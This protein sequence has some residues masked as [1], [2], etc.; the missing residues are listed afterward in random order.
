MTIITQRSLKDIKNCLELVE[1]VI[2]L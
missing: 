2:N 1:N